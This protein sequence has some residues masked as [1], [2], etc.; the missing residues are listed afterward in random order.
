MTVTVHA[1]FDDQAFRKL[2]RTYRA[3]SKRFFR[4]N[5]FLKQFAKECAQLV[6]IPPRH[7]EP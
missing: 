4:S 6:R 2:I 7:S 3:R 5:R 1:E